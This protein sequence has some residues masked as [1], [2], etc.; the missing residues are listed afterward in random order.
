[1]EQPKKLLD[2]VRDVCRVKHYSRRT[3]DAYTDWIK[4][5]TLRVFHKKRHPQDMGVK[6]IEAF[7]THLAVEGNVAASTQNQA[8]SALLL[9]YREVLRIDLPETIN[10]VRAKKPARLPVVLT[11]AETHQVIDGLTG[12]SQLMAKLLYGSGLRLM[13]CIRLRIK[14]IDFERRE[15][16]VRDPQGG[17]E[18]VTMLAASLVAPLQEHLKRVN[19]LHDQDLAAGYGPVYLP[20]ALDRKYPNAATEWGWQY[21]FPSDR[22]SQDPRTGK[23]RRHHMDESSLQRAVKQA[24]KIAGLNKPISCHTFRHSFATHLLESGYDIRTVQ[25]LLGHKDVKTTTPFPSHRL[26]G[27]PGVIYT[28]VLNRGGLAVRSPLD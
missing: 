12:T 7:L 23:T 13:E 20:H 22:L 26:G 11:P 5:Y 17:H 10:A 18:R 27:A 14:D 6:E 28:H 4:R 15:I 25:E 9:L 2:Q 16:I 19:L 21:V 1:M 3:E 24:V 8:L